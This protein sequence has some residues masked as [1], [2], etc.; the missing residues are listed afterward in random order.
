M[1]RRPTG[2]LGEMEAS[3]FMEHCSAWGPVLSTSGCRGELKKN[4]QGPSER[5]AWTSYEEVSW[6]ERPRSR[7]SKPPAEACNCPESAVTPEAA[8]PSVSLGL[9][10][11]SNVCHHE[12]VGDGSSDTPASKLC[13]GDTP[14]FGNSSTTSTRRSSGI[15]AFAGEDP[16]GVEAPE[17]LVAAAVAHADADAHCE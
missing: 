3:D 2:L 7:L 1:E 13:F 9:V 12:V 10:V 17:K 6:N 5:P 11:W 8:S 15:D 16:A 4:S 14:K